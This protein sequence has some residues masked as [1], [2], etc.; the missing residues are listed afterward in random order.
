MAEKDWEDI[1]PSA[2][3]LMKTT[4][5]LENEGEWEDIETKLPFSPRE[6][7]GI[8]GRNLKEAA[9]ITYREGISPFVHGSST[10][11]LGL[12]KQ[13][14]QKTG[15][16]DIIYPEQESVVGKSLRGV[17][18]LAGFTVGGALRGGQWLLKG[19]QKVLPKLA[20]KGFLKT[21]TRYGITGTGAGLLQ[22]PEK[23]EGFIRPEER[24][25]QA[26]MFGA[27]GAALPIAGS[28][29]GVLAKSG[30]WI[31]KNVGGVTDATVETIN[32]LGAD[33]VFEPLKAQA[34]YIGKEIVPRVV[35]RTKEILGEGSKLTKGLLSRVGWKAD[36]ID[37]VAKINP[38]TLKNILFRTNVEDPATLTRAIET[39]RLSADMYYKKVFNE[40]TKEK[41]TLGIKNTFYRLKDALE[42]QGWV[43]KQGNKLIGS[44][45][46]NKTKDNLIKIFNDLRKSLV[47][48]GKTR[49]TG[50]ISPR[51][52]LNKLSE[53]DASMVGDLKFDRHIFTLQ[54]SLRD[55]VATQIKGLD[56]ANKLYADAMKLI[57]LEP[58]IQSALDPKGWQ[59]KINQVGKDDYFQRTKILKP[60]VGEQN[61]DDIM[62][63]LANKDFEL[64]TSTP[65]TGGGFYPSRSG[66]LRSAVD[67]GTKRYYQDI[68]PQFLKA[69][70]FGEKTFKN[71]EQE[72]NKPLK[73]PIGANLKGKRGSVGFEEGE[74][75]I[76]EIIEKAGGKF[77][78]FFTE[79][80]SF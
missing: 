80:F 4:P 43:D 77:K 39:N 26:G 64:V 40:G 10:M 45:I 53:L 8:I 69:K 48:E 3:K 51:E 65:G 54:R 60:L 31:A 79:F 12:P 73:F 66:F 22:A 76:K 7:P 13:V 68:K 35:N 2:V 30:R 41:K 59:T 74:G 56:K 21:A 25:E 29:A 11:A 44:G 28:V 47:T 61:Y 38:G 58:K 1:E 71:I 78:G 63:H 33:R 49:V 62:A 24:L 19:A 75:S 50:T 37:E 52:Y 42:K 18:E 70:E 14:A 72:R 6:I 5:T 32:R 17:S 15:T 27:T 46:P 23:G 67:R 20:G 55:E 16:K 9:R 34:E 57:E 36:E